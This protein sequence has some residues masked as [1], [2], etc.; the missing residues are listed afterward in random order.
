MVEL[1]TI[2]SGGRP[3]KE[4]INEKYKAVCVAFSSS[5]LKGTLDNGMHLTV[6]L[7][8]KSRSRHGQV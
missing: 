3:F 2:T 6:I 8:P 7:T 4:W 1:H 5:A